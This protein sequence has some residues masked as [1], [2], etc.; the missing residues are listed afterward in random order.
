MS[1]ELIVSLIVALGGGA[2]VKLIVDA[3]KDR[4]RGITSAAIE[5]EQ[6]ALQGYK[7]LAA[8]YKADLAALKTEMR[9]TQAA[10]AERFSRIETELA[11][12]RSTRWAAVQYAREL[13]ALIVRLLPGTTVPEPPESLADHIIIPRKDL[14]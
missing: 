11:V 12:E 10:N 4:R 5:Q 14:P 9:E 1:P 3:I 7:D 2:T 8:E 6:N 13:V